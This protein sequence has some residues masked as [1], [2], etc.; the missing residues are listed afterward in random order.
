MANATTHRPTGRTF[1]MRTAHGHANA[2]AHA[3]LAT[4]SDAGPEPT[5]RAWLA[6]ADEYAA[7]GHNQATARVYRM[8]AAIAWRLLADGTTAPEALR[9]HAWATLDAIRHATANGAPVCGE[10]MAAAVALADT[11]PGGMGRLFGD[12]VP[13]L[14]DAADAPVWA[15]TPWAAAALIDAVAYNADI[16]DA[17]VVAAVAGMRAAMPAT[18]T[19]ATH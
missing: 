4:E 14:R 9:T 18:R 1:D 8:A 2:M 15:D 7:C 11:M 17:D 3:A 12:G 13:E 16:T 19:P 10:V 5:L 6:T